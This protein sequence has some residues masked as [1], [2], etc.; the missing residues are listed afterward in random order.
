MHLLAVEGGK[1]TKPNEFRSC[2]RRRGPAPGRRLPS[3]VRWAL[4]SSLLVC[5]SARAAFVEIQPGGIGPSPFPRPTA[6]PRPPR[7]VDPCKLPKGPEPLCLGPRVDEV[8]TI[9]ANPVL[10][11]T[12]GR[13]VAHH[14]G[15]NAVLASAVRTPAVKK[16]KGPQAWV[17][18]LRGCRLDQIRSIQVEGSGVTATVLPASSVADWLSSEPTLPVGSLLQPVAPGSFVLVRFEVAGNAHVEHERDIAVTF[19][20]ESGTSTQEL[21]RI[22]LQVAHNGVESRRRPLEVRWEEETPLVFSG[23]RLADARF[24]GPAC[25]KQAAIDANGETSLA[26]TATFHCPVAVPGEPGVTVNDP[27]CDCPIVAYDRA[28]DVYPELPKRTFN[29][30]SSPLRVVANLDYL[31]QKPAV[32]GDS[33]SHGAFSG[34]VTERSQRWAYPHQVV[35]QMGGTPLVQNIIHSGPNVE[36]TVKTILFDRYGPAPGPFRLDPQ[37]LGLL[38]EDAVTAGESTELPTHTGV[39]GFDYTNVL[40]TSGICLDEEHA[41]ERREG[42]RVPEQICEQRCEDADGNELP[43]PS[44]DAQL[45]L[46]CSDKTPIEMM[47]QIEPTFVFAAAAPNHALA[48]AV[49]TR[50]EECLEWDRFERDAAEVFR[51][52]RRIR[53]IKGGVVFGIPPLGSIPYLIEHRPGEVCANGAKK[54]RAF[55]KEDLFL[56]EDEIIDCEERK[57]LDDFIV[58]VNERLGELAELNRY[59][60]LDSIT[61]FERLSDEG[62]PIRDEDGEEVCRAGTD[63][64]RREIDI[65]PDGFEFPENVGSDAGCGIFS[66][67]GAHPSQFGHAVMANELIRGIDEYYGV[68]IPPLDDGELL[69]IW[70]DDDLAQDPIEMDD[71]MRLD[72]AEAVGEGVGVAACIAPALLCAATNGIACLGVAQIDAILALTPVRDL[73]LEPV[74]RALVTELGFKP[75]DAAVEPSHCWDDHC[76]VAADA[77]PTPG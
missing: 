71:F 45:A 4:L 17:M 64:P 37:P 19:G 75:I 14:K 67:D 42:A 61:T 77:T 72:P 48:C 43:S 41:A 34:T 49:T 11:K 22:R 51:R 21:E 52:L 5:G 47:E 55:W 10:Q 25:V 2:G 20:S 69:A 56:A 44:V 54:L 8:G 58:A 62:L 29:Y 28:L 24:V 66:L 33:L 12:C 1:M 70:E 9:Q 40:R 26:V 46:G 32:I 50:I 60:Y 53:S 36:D 18:A 23:A 38:E 57:L 13:F 7:E 6:S 68:D 39:A 27:T 35:L 3:I 15:G 63:W 31:R 74:V 65:G 73:C 76:P 30:F 16:R 59:A